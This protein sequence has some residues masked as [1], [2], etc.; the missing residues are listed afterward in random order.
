M[1]IAVQDAF[2]KTVG[3][4]TKGCSSGWGHTQE[5]VDAMWDARMTIYK[6]RN[7]IKD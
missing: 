1:R 3:R 2:K 7:N 5:E 6:R 4:H